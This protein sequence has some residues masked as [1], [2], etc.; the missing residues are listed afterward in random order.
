MNNAAENNVF[1]SGLTAINEVHMRMDYILDYIYFFF[2]QSE[3]C[4]KAL[5]G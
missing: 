5:T 3:L 4:N 2:H 1:G